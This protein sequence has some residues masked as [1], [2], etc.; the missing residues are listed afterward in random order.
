[1][2]DLKSLPMGTNDRAV[3]LLTPPHSLLADIVAT[4][5]KSMVGGAC[6]E[7]SSDCY[8]AVPFLKHHPQGTVF[9]LYERGGGG[10]FFPLC[11]NIPTAFKIVFLTEPAMLDLWK[12]D[13]KINPQG[14]WHCDDINADNLVP[15]FKANLDRYPYY[16]PSIIKMLNQKTELTIEDLQMLRLLERGI[17]TKDLDQFLP[18]SLPTIGRRKKRLKQRFQVENLTDCA[19]VRKAREKGLI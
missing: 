3:F 18:E 7:R 17:H 2:E 9:V 1:M 5:L 16:S 15:T 12:L 13:Q 6:F 10:D 14:L 11:K 19:L 4:A 8:R